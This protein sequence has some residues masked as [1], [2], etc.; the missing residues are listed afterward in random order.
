MSRLV[1]AVRAHLLLPVLVVVV[2]VVGGSLGARLPNDPLPTCG[3][4][5]CPKSD[6]KKLNIHLVPHTHD[7][8][9]WLKTV[10]QYYFGGRM[11][12]QVAGV[13]YIIDSVVDAL[14]HDPT[15]KFIYV[16]T[17]YLW[18][19]WVH[20]SEERKEIMKKLVNEGRLEIIGG[21]WSMNDEAVTHYH[22]I[23]DQFTWGFRRLND[24]FGSCARP[25]IGWQIDPFGHSREQAS[26]F[27]Q[28]GFDGMFFA[29]LDYQDKSKRLQTKTGEFIWKGSPSLGNAA[30]LFTSVLYNF[31]SAPAG[32]CFDILC[33]DTEPIV[34]DLDSPEYNIASK[35]D[36]FLKYAKL[37]ATSYKTN[38]IILTMGEDFNYLYAGMWYTNMDKLIRYI[39]EINGT[40]FNAFYSTPSCYTKAVNEANLTWSSKTDDFFPYA[41]D[42]HSFWTGYF[43]S[44]PTL[45]FFERMGNSFLQIVK[46]LLVLTN[47]PD[48]D[49]L[50]LFREAMGIMQ[51]HDAITGTEKQHVAA[52]YARILHYNMKNGEKLASKA[53]RKLSLKKD[54]VEPATFHSC[55][56]LNI[57]SCEHTTHNTTFVVTLYNPTSQPLTT[58]VRLPVQD[59]FYQVLDHSGK[60]IVTQIVPIPTA[61]LNIP[62]R[63]SEAKAELLFQAVATPALGYQSFYV[64]QKPNELKKVEN[65]TTTPDEQTIDGEFYKVSIDSEGK[66][67]VKSLKKDNEKVFKQS[68][69]Y[70][71]GMQGNN[72]V[73][74]NRSS[75]AYIFR[76]KYNYTKNVSET[77]TYKIYKG[78]IV[79]EIHQV[80]SSWISQV[81]RIYKGKDYV[82]FDW[83]VG[84]IPIEDNIGKEIITKYSSNLNNNAEFLTDS[85][86]RE[87]LKRKLN[88][89]PTWNITLQEKVSGNYY[90]ITT[91]ISIQDANT[92][93]TFSVL[94]DRAQGGS[95]LNNGEIEL[96][97]HRRL[98]S[99][100]AFGVSE[101][102][103]EF[104]FGEGLVVRGQHYV[105]NGNL[106][107]ADETLLQEKE[108]AFQSAVS[109]WVFITP[110]SQ[111]FE[112]WNECYKMRSEGLVKSLP[113]NVR[114][115]TLEPWKDGEVLL[116]LEHF[117]EKNESKQYSVSVDIDIKELFRG[118]VV[119]SV[120]ETTL[121]G[122]Q[123][124][125]DLQRLKWQLES[126]EVIKAEVS[127]E[128]SESTINDKIIKHFKPMEIRTFVVKLSLETTT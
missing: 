52:D 67:V 6:L 66:V 16:E 21:A 30:N 36:K 19:W 103:N 123:W 121:G 56:L 55:L 31:Y 35:V 13:Q 24:T 109:P 7:D 3:Y 125:E 78:A 122:N 45:K 11:N 5:S 84:P 53:L 37:Q 127:S 118:F 20:Q 68:F 33:Q 116:R 44:R 62:G 82:E 51:H 23:I 76:P 94:I 107:N 22:S 15:R 104:A 10:D 90:P 80:L 81:I 71:E 64:S 86:G 92:N 14:Q 48:L 74:I 41:S 79:E 65:G 113:R 124:I 25:K 102:L 96:M 115:L 28:L 69:H 9:G 63:S 128:K 40:N 101:P 4:D 126:N 108:L 77:S 114:I 89:R 42:P 99:D 46:Q 54:I 98:L 106:Q 120:R 17:A 88:Y 12:I 72:R 29:R 2:I 1:S 97:L 47:Q 91:K 27:A 110:V 119:H 105:V 32:F 26:I 111:S 85:N 34:D 50:E 57:S 18:K 95:S 58:Y 93:E 117:F 112:K 61:V 73:Y 38:N 70:Y 59:H 39:N 8:V 83:L 49:E 60:E 75:G 43:T 87:M 100:D